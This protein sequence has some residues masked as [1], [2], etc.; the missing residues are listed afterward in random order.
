LCRLAREGHPVMSALKVFGL[1]AA[2]LGAY[3]AGALTQ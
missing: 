1:I 2:I 3:L